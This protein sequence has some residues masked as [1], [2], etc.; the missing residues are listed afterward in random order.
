MYQAY[1]EVIPVD[2]PR[3]ARRRRF[4]QLLACAVLSLVAMHLLLGSNSRT[5]GLGRLPYKYGR[6][7]CSDAVNWTITT[8]SLGDYEYHASTSFSLPLTAADLHFVAEGSLQYGEFEMSHDVDLVSDS[9]LID[10]SVEYQHPDAIAEATV[11]RLH[12]SE[13]QWGLGIFTPHWGA[14]HLDRNLKFRIHVHFPATSSHGPLKLNSLSTH[15]P[16]FAHQLPDLANSL[17]F[18]SVKLVTENAL[19]TADSIAG[20]RVWCTTKNGAIRGN[21]TAST[22]LDLYTSNAPIDV[23]ARL[24]NG[25]GDPSHLFLKTSNGRV[26]GSIALASNGTDPASTAFH[27]VARTSNTPLALAITAAPPD[28]ALTLTASTS[29]GPADVALPRAFAGMF[30]LASSSVFRPT[31]DWSPAAAGD[32]DPAGR[33]RQRRVRLDPLKGRASRLRGSVSWEDGDEERGRVAVET[34]NAMLTVTL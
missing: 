30:D 13:E 11:C 12:P 15:L 32:S 19:I 33:G 26:D 16:L 7:Q 10:V 2:H 21:F 23:S 3:P 20:D 18:A 24:I 8:D 34:T 22:S 6:S 31:L 14:F 1:I 25:G 27:V 9:A 17:H 5:K 28:S 29:N 4:W